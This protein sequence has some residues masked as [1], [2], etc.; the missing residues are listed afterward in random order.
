MDALFLD[1]LTARFVKLRNSKDIGDLDRETPYLRGYL[2][3]LFHCNAISTD[4]YG[5]LMELTTNVW[6]NRFEEFC[7]MNAT[8]NGVPF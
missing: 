2:A 7:S 8:T 3:G 1:Q 4:T 5:I 6:N